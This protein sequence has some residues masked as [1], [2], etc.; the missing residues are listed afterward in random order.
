MSK[1]IASALIVL[2]LVLT[3]CGEAS[4]YQ[5]VSLAL[6]PVDQL[7]SLPGESLQVA[8]AAVISPQGTILSYTPLLEYLGQHLNQPVTLLQRQTYDE[9]NGLIRSGKVDLAFICTGAYVQGGEELGA[10]LLVVPQVGGETVYYSYIIV[11]ADSG[12]QHF[13]DLRGHTFA[14]TDPLSNTGRLSAVHRLWQQ[15]ETPESF[16]SETIY[17][18]SHD[19]S[20]RAVSDG[21]VDGAA[22]DSLVYDYLIQREPSLAQK[23]RIVEQS[24]PY[25]IPPVVVPKGADDAFK[26][27]AFRVLTNMHQDAVGR[28]ILTALGIE[29]FVSVDDAVYNSVRE[30]LADLE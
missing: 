2:L 4:D 16:F 6:Q 28:A 25:G 12:I 18:F 29:R 1:T 14:F 26:E 11:A 22:V 19:N 3:A 15:D 5:E 23:V 21:L 10:E 27:E 17:T 8:V 30:M 7:P 24:V 13:A 20:I 9:V